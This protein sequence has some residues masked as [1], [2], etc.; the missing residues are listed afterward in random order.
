MVNN[1]VG[2][3]IGDELNCNMLVIMS[4]VKGKSLEKAC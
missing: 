3:Q 4:C 2:G 1:V